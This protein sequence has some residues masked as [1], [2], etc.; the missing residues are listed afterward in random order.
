MCKD[1]IIMRDILNI[2]YDIFKDISIENIVLGEFFYFYKREIL[3]IFIY[4]N[5]VE[6][7]VIYRWR[8]G[9]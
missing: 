7:S 6:L 9:C 1:I 3:Y 2:I 8:V 5:F 4:V